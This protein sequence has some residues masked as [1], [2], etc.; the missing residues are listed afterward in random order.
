[1]KKMEPVSHIVNGVVLANGIDKEMEEEY[2]F[3]IKE[4]SLFSQEL[5]HQV[6]YIFAEEIWSRLLFDTQNEIS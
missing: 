4:I 1:M 3:I 5:Q 6:I 2:K